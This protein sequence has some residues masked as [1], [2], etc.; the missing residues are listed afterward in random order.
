MAGAATRLRNR[1]TG[2]APIPPAAA[3]QSD[4]VAI[5]LSAETAEARTAQRALDA[6]GWIG[7]LLFQPPV[8]GFIVHTRRLCLG[9]HCEQRIDAR[10][11]RPLAEEIGAKTVNGADLR[12][13]EPAERAVEPVALSGSACRRFLGPLRALRADAA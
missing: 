2:S 10:F 8:K 12:L 11:D 9:Q 1:A 6:F 13:F 7:E 5:R 4:L 3:G